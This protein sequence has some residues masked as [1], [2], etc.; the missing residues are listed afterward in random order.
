MGSCVALVEWPLPS[1]FTP[2]HP[3]LHH[4][5]YQSPWGLPNLQGLPKQNTT[6]SSLWLQSW[7]PQDLCWHCS[8][9]CSCPLQWT[10]SSQMRPS[11][12]TNFLRALAGTKIGF[13]QPSCWH[14]TCS[15]FVP[16]PSSQ[17]EP[18][19]PLCSTSS[20]PEQLV[21]PFTSLNLKGSAGSGDGVGHGKKKKKKHIIYIL[22][23]IPSTL[24]KLSTCLFFCDHSPCS[25]FQSM[26]P[27]SVSLTKAFY[28][29]I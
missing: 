27:R 28:F 17:T 9:D 13:P 23:Q 20:R 16:Q 10:S 6:T 29:P 22:I 7:Y 1:E 3:L 18:H 21:S 8:R 15:S 25:N 26:Y 5:P 12:G 2:H 4:P 11:P 24:L 14:T 19:M